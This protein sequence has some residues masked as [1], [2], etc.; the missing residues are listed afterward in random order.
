M[1]GYLHIKTRSVSKERLI[2]IHF[3]LVNFLVEPCSL[4]IDIVIPRVFQ[5]NDFG[6]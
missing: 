3:S 2:N 4:N 1:S 6:K 5:E